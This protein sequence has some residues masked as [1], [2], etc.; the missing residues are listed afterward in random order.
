M[1]RCY[2]LLL[3]FCCVQI[4]CS[5]A[6]CHCP[7]YK[8]SADN[9]AMALYRST[10]LTCQAMG[11]Q[12]LGES[13]LA[14]SALDS[15]A[16]YLLQAEKYFEAA[17]CSDQQKLPLLKSI[18]KMYYQQMD[19]RKSAEY[20]L[21]MIQLAE[22]SR[23]YV[24]LMNAY[25]QMAELYAR[26]GQPAEGL[27]YTRKAAPYAEKLE[28]SNLKADLL[29]RLGSRY[30]FFYQDTREPHLLDTTSVLMKAALALA[31]QR[32]YSKGMQVAYNKMNTLA[33][34]EKNYR[35]AL[36][37]LDSAIAIGRTLAPNAAL[38]T[39]FGDKGNVLLKMR[40]YRE[41]EKWADSC[42][43]YNQ[44]L[45]FPPLIANAYSLIAEIADSS[46][47]YSKAYWALSQEKKINDS[48]LQIDKL[49][50]VNEIDKK[51]QQAKNEKTIR[52]LSLQR[53]LFG[54]FGL[55]ALL[56]IGLVA[57]FFRQQALQHKQTIMETEQRLNRARM[58]P[59]FFFNALTA[60]QR[61]AM[62]ENDGKAL[63]ANLSKFSHIMRETLESTY[64]EYVTIKQEVEF[65]KEYLEIQKIR[66]PEKFSYSLMVDGQLDPDDVL[67]PS[68][69]VQPFVENSIEHGFAGIKYPGEIR[70]DFKQ[71]DKNITIEILD[72]GKGLTS[73]EMKHSEHISRAS[74]IIKDRIY[75]LN[76][77][78]KTK[79]NFSI[80]NMPD[81]QGVIVKIHLPLLYKDE[82]T[83][84]R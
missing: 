61:F 21:K 40:E 41:A 54:M 24:E 48:L 76:I 33:F 38:A 36:L 26:M 39:S 35:Q 47:N 58:N 19:Y 55:V 74:Q 10:S 51:Y 72:N 66:F 16:Y 63:A 78:L 7:E 23:D 44:L 80:D 9:D 18:A 20:S 3:F 64:K 11:A 12:L 57:F 8:K 71:N 59:H 31:K 69:I 77:K 28:D 37:Y 46:G 6:E 84:Y 30:Y 43:Y 1:F 73:H 25:L 27:K 82:S 22:A 45:D 70:I 81:N 60:M 13:F 68:M 49:K 32:N 42:L 4:T 29:L 83:D 34:S 15:A 75:L 53:F 5:A 65:L 2:S 56:G 62:Q 17:K 67:I 52:E 14:S 50:A 79:A